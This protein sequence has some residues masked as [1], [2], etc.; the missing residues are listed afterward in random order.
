MLESFS[1]I[2]GVSSLQVLLVLVTV[3]FASVLRSFTGFGFALA[4]VPVFAV[5]LPATD[6][7]VLSASLTL[8]LSVLALPTYW[9]VVPLRPMAPLFAMALV[10]TAVGAA[11]LQSVS[12][13]QFQLW[14]GV[15]VTLASLAL[16]IFRPSA[17]R[18][19]P[20][21][22]WLTGLASG[23]MNGVMAIPG[24][25]VILYALITEP[26]PAQSRALL[27][28]YFFGSAL[29]ALT[30]FGLA[31]FVNVQTLSLALLASPVLYFGDRM[32]YYLFR[33]YGD[34][35][36]RRIAMMTLLVIGVSVTCQALW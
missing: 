26:A 14:A 28:T 18:L 17:G 19:P 7:V 21:W 25:P 31:G 9:G 15:A 1:E 16:W 24:P 4:A 5:I 2:F 6:A 11:V 13:E 35:F 32:G 12:V 36:Y 30:I 33:R 20:L 3:V 8:V 34:Q 29:F 10:G 27:M 22:A 23:L